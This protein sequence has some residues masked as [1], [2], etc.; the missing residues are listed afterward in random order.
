MLLDPAIQKE[1]DAWLHKSREDLRAAAVDLAAQPP[2]LADSLFH[3]QQACE[4]SLKA[5]L[6]AMQTPF[7]KT[8]DLNEL[9]ALAMGSFPELDPLLDAIAHMTSFAVESRYPSDEPAPE[10]E[11]VSENFRLASHF[12]DEISQILISFK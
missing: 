8:H 12:V 5:S 11:E 7:R 1:M 9:G 10:W 3:C 2:L 6:C 4:K